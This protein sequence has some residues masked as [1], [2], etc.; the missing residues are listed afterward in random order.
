MSFDFMDRFHVG[1]SDARTRSFTA[2][3][4]AE[5]EALTGDVAP[6]AGT[7]PVGMLGGMVS[8]LL[9]TRLPGRG[10]N[11]LKQKLVYS[12]VARVGEPVTTRLEI[13]RLRPDKA[14]VNLESTCTDA[15]GA[16]ICRGESL[17]LVRELELR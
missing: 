8:E 5:H 16:V 14:L 6:S 1:Q 11:W 4:V 13:V 7:V 2:E 10:T 12:G 3:E 17:V 15:H 9:G